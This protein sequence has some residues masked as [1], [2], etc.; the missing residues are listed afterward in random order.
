[1]IGCHHVNVVAKLKYF[2]L[3]KLV[4]L[5]ILVNALARA[6]QKCRATN[7]NLSQLYSSEK[8]PQFA[9]GIVLPLRVWCERTLRQEGA[10]SCFLLNSIFCS[11][12]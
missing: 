7:Q 3:S 10:G 12:G 2:N 8:F 5:Q 6:G 1:M 4:A 11:L 9:Y